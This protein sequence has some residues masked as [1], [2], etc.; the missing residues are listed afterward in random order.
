MG[1]E[2][3]GF[4]ETLVFKLD[5]IDIFFDLLRMAKLNKLSSIGLG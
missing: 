5:R 4:E 2:N 3:E 1:L